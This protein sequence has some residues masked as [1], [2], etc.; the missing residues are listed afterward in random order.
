MCPDELIL[1]PAVRGSAEDRSASG[2]QAK[3]K[4]GGGLCG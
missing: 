1:L 4:Q 2:L 3:A